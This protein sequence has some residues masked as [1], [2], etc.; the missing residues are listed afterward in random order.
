MGSPKALLPWRGVPMIAH[1]VGVVSTVVP[2]IV[3]VS[4]AGLKLPALPAH[5]RVIVDSEPGRGPLASLRDGLREIRADLTF[6]TSTDAPF[7]T[8][9]FIETMFS[10]G[11]AAAPELDGF[12]QPLAAVYPKTLSAL[13]AS[14]LGEPR[15]GLTDLLKGANARRVSAKE[16]PDLKSLETFN[17]PEEYDAALKIDG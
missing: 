3:V 15:A 9:S 7:L 12:L 2:E 10:F 6:A 13:A 14:M 1:V 5:V 4:S 16:L 8:A 17:T 11:G